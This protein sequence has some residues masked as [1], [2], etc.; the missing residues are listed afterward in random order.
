MTMVACIIVAM[1]TYRL[2]STII[3]IGIAK[4]PGSVST[5]RGTTDTKKMIDLGLKMFD[6][7]PRKNSGLTVLRKSARLG[8]LSAW[9]CQPSQARNRR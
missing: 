7:K 6:R 4:A 9:L 1:P 8:E 2:P 3:C 5:N